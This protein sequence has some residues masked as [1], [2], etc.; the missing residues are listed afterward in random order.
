MATFEKMDAMLFLCAL[1]RSK[2]VYI[3]LAS[4]TLSVGDMVRALPP[5]GYL[6]IQHLL[7]KCRQ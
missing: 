6:G 2:S 7:C 4:V 3:N 1:C 5:S